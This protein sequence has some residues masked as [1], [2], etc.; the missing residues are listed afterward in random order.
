M[1]LPFGMVIYGENNIGKKGRNLL[2]R[3][4]YSKYPRCYP[5]I[6]QKTIKWYI[7]GFMLGRKLNEPNR[8]MHTWKIHV[9]SDILFKKKKWY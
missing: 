7:I 6:N 4:P 3:N 2:S 1:V 5:L 8:A 9:Y